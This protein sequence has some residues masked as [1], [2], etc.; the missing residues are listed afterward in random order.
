MRRGRYPLNSTVLSCRQNAQI[1][2]IRRRSAGK[3]FHTV[4]YYNLRNVRYHVVAEE[5][6]CKQCSVLAVINEKAYLS[7]ECESYHC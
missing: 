1:A 5:S 6:V 4:N 7:R 2:S 3:L